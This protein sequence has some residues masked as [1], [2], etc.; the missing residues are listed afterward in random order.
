MAYLTAA[1]VFF[2]LLCVLDLVLTFGVIR[3]L[4]EM[5]TEP[6]MGRAS[7][8]PSHIEAGAV[9]AR[10]TAIDVD[11]L[12]VTRQ[13]LTR[14]HLVAFVSP[15]CPTCEDSLPS[16]VARAAELGPRRILAVVVLDEDKGT[17]PDAFVAALAPAARVVV[18]RIDDEL[19]RAF[20]IK[21]LPAYVVT[22][23]DGRVAHS[24]IVLSRT[25]RP[26]E[27]DA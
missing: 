15:G 11:G 13:D 27:V 18:T 22:G 14:D 21:G 12:P 25:P 16:L 2:G 23:P 20:G 19:P 4:R 10:F 1:V 9:A 3:R 26:A 24:D 8:D 6:A 5:G 17:D 7:S